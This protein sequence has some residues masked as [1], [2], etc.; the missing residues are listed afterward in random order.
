M[1]SYR[2]QNFDILENMIQLDGFFGI[3]V[4]GQRQTGFVKK[5]QF[6]E[7]WNCGARDARVVRVFRSL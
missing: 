4:F 3:H 5:Y 2:Y 7:P 1:K 6:H